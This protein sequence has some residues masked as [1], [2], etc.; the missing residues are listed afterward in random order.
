[1]ETV[2]KSELI[3]TKEKKSCLQTALNNKITITHYKLEFIKFISIV[4]YNSL[5]PNNIT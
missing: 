5:L 3:S 2:L 4:P 1:M